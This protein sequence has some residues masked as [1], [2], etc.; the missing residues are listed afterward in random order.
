MALQPNRRNR[1]YDKRFSREIVRLADFMTSEEVENLLRCL[2]GL[3]QFWEEEGARRQ[4][5]PW[6]SLLRRWVG[7]T[8]QDLP[9]TDTDDFVS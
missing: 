4:H 2:S 5:E 7:E 8:C 9:D 1:N 6:L 3:F